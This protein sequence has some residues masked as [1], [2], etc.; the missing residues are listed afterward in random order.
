M[1]DYY[2]MGYNGC[3]FCHKDPHFE[4][5]AAAGGNCTDCHLEG[6]ANATAGLPIISKN[7]F[8]NSLHTNITGDFNATN[9]SDIS[10]VCW[11]CH[12]NYTEELIDPVHTRRA[13]EL[14]DCEDCH[15]NET[16]LPTV[17]SATTIHYL[18]RYRQ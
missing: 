14:P 6:G 8:F 9:Y 10:R 16:P 15:F 17:L 18:F 3:M 2:D 1:T 11:G 4:P 5:E 12:V 13:T 7:G